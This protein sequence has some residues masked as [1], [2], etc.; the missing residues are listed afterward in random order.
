MVAYRIL[1]RKAFVTHLV[2]ELLRG[3]EET[4]ILIL[5]N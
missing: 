4:I 3:K 1:V 2:E 5:E